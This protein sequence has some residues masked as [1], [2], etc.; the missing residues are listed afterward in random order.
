MSDADRDNYRLQSRA[1]FDGVATACRQNDI[2]QHEARI[3]QP[4]GA[5]LRSWLR[6]AGARAR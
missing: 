1:H 3:E 4:V 5:V 6:L 2:V